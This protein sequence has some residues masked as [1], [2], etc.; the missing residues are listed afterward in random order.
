MGAVYFYHMTQSPV[1][2]TLPQLLGK[3]RGAGWRVVVRGRD[4]ETLARLDATLW[5]GDGF[6]PHGLAGGAH[7]ADQPILLTTGAEHD[8]CLVSLEGAEINPDEVKASER[9]MILFDGANGD[10]VAHARTQW[11][12]LTEGGCSAQYWAQEDGS[13][14][15]KAESG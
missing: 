10:A 1:E 6:L 8:A 7:D 15:K 12:L 2:V 11:K 9:A 3:A 4:P 5:D 14:I 13:W